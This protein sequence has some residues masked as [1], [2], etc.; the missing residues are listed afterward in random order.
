MPFN[1]NRVVVG[2]LSFAL[3][4]YNATMRKHGVANVATNLMTRGLAALFF[5]S[6]LA[7]GSGKHQEVRVT[8]ILLFVAGTAVSA[9]LLNWQIRAPLMLASV[10]FATALP[11]LMS[12]REAG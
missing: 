3:G 4:V 7:G 1:V 5:E 2:L 6:T 12:G 10:G 11:A 9:F 8:S